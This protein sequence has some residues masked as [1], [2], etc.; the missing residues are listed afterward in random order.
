MVSK[1]LILTVEGVE[2]GTNNIPTFNLDELKK[3]RGDMLGRGAFG[4]VYAINGFPGLAVKEIRLDG[5]P[6]RLVEITKFELEALSQFS[7]PGVLKYHQVIEDGDFFYV[8]MDRYHGDL[9][10]FITDH[11]SV[12][13]HIPKEL[14]LSIVRQLA[15][16]LAYVHAPYKVNERGGVL[17]SIVHRNLKPANVLMSRDGERVVI[18]DFGLC[19]DALRSGSTFAGSPAYMAPETLLS[20][21]TSPASDIWALGVITYELAALKR[22]NFLEGREPKDVFI[23]G[24]KPDLSDVKNDF[25]RGILEKIFVLDPEERPTAKELAELLQEPN[26]PTIELKAPISALDERY[27]SLEA[28]LNGV[29]ARLELLESSLKAKTDEI[30]SLREVLATK[31][32]EIGTLESTIATQAAEMGAL[33]KDLKTKS[34]QIDAL[35][36]QCKEHLAMMK[37]L[38]DKIALLAASNPQSGLFLLPRL[39]RAAHTNSVETVRMLV[40]SG[41]GIGKRDEQGRTALMHAAQQGHVEPAR[42]LVEKEKGLQDGDGW[43]ALMHAA[44]NNHPE[45]VEILI[46]CERGKRDNSRRTAL[47]IAAE[48]GYTE[49]VTALA[50]HEKGLTDSSGNTALMFAASNAHIETVRMLVE[51]EKGA[52]DSHSRT[53]LMTAAQR[54]G[55][56]MVKILAEH[57]KG[58]TDEDG[59]TALVLAARAGHRETAELLMEHE[60]DVTGWT[61]LMCAAALGDADM[62]SQHIGERGQKDKQGRTALILAA[63]NGRDEVVKLLMKHEGGA[64]GWTS[65]IYAAYF[66]DVDSAR[67][68]LHERGRKDDVGM[69]ALMWAVRR[70]HK[71][72][73]KVLLEHEKSLKDTDGNT[74]FMHALRNKHTD[75]ATV[76]RKHE[77]PSWTFLMCAAFIGD[78]E[79]AKSHLSDKDKKN[80]DGDTALIIAAKAG[81]E[82]IV[83]LLDQTDENGVTALMRAAERGDVEAV[84]ALMSLQK[85]KTASCVTIGKCVILRGTALM[86]AASCGHAEVVRLLVE[87]EGGMQDNCGYTAPMFAAKSGHADCAKLLLEREI[88]MQDKIGVTALMFAALGNHTECVKLLTEKEKKIRNAGGK[89]ALDI[90]KNC[91]HIDVIS[92]L[93]K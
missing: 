11:K 19:K 30:G 26:V 39:M 54:G 22:P 93:T 74:A 82:D 47:M 64:S 72:V 68:N 75:I 61:M 14:M 15:D 73:V 71:G 70:E 34:N 63:Q 13:K 62:V 79:L 81:Y 37:A 51:H 45:V 9:Q 5:Q 20:N 44:H 17:P 89:T 50:P 27:K 12:Q 43:T 83:E 32:A 21:K 66:G 16:A 10:H 36:G 40:E 53:A 48:R 6:D 38:E 1:D 91:G 67:D 35:E 55:L 92:T 33:K 24:W 8:V 49:I 18:A 46:T 56:E 84:R 31:S 59:H 41:D 4:K 86:R 85:G 58:M 52:R 77:A 25:I 2:N 78:I 28:A 42:L 80:R 90:A 69:T 87:H 23:D 88:C 60:K 57:E 76:L 29:N 3:H 7:H 65:L